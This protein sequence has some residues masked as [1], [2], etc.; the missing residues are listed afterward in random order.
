[1]PSTGLCSGIQKKCK[2]RVLPKKSFSAHWESKANTHSWNK[3]IVWHYYVLVGL[4]Q[5]WQSFLRWGN[6]FCSCCSTQWPV[7]TCG[8][9]ALKMWVLGL[10]RRLRWSMQED[11]GQSLI[12]EDPTCCTA[13]KPMHHNHW[14]HAPQLSKPLLRGTHAPLEKHRSE[15]LAHL[16]CRV[17]PAR[18]D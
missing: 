10:P 3:Y 18:W 5:N 15:K 14:A 2:R 13:T 6:S 11:M 7:A 16:N 17:A 4:K 9:W 8:C 12:W 1:M